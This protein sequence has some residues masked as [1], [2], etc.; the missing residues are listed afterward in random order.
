MAQFCKTTF[1]LPFL[2]RNAV[3]GKPETAHLSLVTAADWPGIVSSARVVFRQLGYTTVYP[4]DFTVFVVHDHI[5]PTSQKAIYAQ[6][7]RAF[8][9]VSIDTLQK[10]VRQFYAERPP[11][12]ALRA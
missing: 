8:T 6:H 12:Q 3:N 9:P 1:P 2:D 5:T 7:E 10:Q 11:V 4:D